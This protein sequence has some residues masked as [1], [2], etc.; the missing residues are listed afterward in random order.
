MAFAVPRLLRRVRPALA[1]FVHALPLA[2]PCPAVLTVQDLSFERDPSVMGRATGSS[3]ARASRAPRAA[4][5]ACS[6]S[7]R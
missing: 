7:R 3:S 4:R 1:H 5:P 6:R 2:C